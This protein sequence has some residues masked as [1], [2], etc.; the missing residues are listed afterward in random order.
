M[1][2]PEADQADADRREEEAIDAREAWLDFAVADGDTGA[3]ALATAA[4][5]GRPL[6]R[7]KPADMPAT[8]L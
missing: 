6:P 5:R 7:R 1:A 2:T 4:R 8:E 3:A